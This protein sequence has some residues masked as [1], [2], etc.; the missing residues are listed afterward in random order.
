MQ[1]LPIAFDLGPVMELLIKKSG[2][3]YRAA[4]YAL[5][6][7]KDA[8]SAFH[9]LSYAAELL[10]HLSNDNPSIE[11]DDSLPFAVRG[12]L[13]SNVI[14]LYVRATTPG[15]TRT[16]KPGGSRKHLNIYKHLTPEQQELHNQ[17]GKL[18]N[19][20][21]AHLDK[22]RSFRNKTMSDEVLVVIHTPDGGQRLDLADRRVASQ[23]NMEAELRDLISAAMS[24]GWDIV[25]EK[26]KDAAKYLKKVSEADPNIGALIRRSAFDAISFWG[27]EKVARSFLEDGYVVSSYAER[28]RSFFDY[29]P[30][31]A[32]N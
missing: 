11:S 26:Y 12:A 28:G 15:T 31:P 6:G 4:G 2:T 1:K 16:T 10:H 19:K 18:R 29:W 25:N 22:D 7:V 13:F 17:L 14:L 30:N 23:N 8:R 5:K 20:T 27:N 24:L 21:I 3:D 32:G 9:D